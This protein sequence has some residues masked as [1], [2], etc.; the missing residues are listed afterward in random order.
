VSGVL[1]NL[2]IYYAYLKIFWSWMGFPRATV[3][4]FWH[5]GIKQQWVTIARVLKWLLFGMNPAASGLGFFWGSDPEITELGSIWQLI[6]GGRAALLLDVVFEEVFKRYFGA[7]GTAAIV[8]VEAACHCSF[9]Y[10]PVATMHVAAS[11]LPLTGGV[12]LHYLWNHRAVNSGG[13]KGKLSDTILSVRFVPGSSDL[14]GVCTKDS[15]LDLAFPAKRARLLKWPSERPDCLSRSMLWRIGPTVDIS[16]PLCFYS[17]PHNDVAAVSRRI[18]NGTAR[19]DSDLRGHM[20]VWRM[21]RS[22]NLLP[23]IITY[24]VPQVSFDGWAA[25]YPEAFRKRLS[26]WKESFEQEGLTSSDFKIEAFVK[27]ERLPLTLFSSDDKDRKPRLIQGRRGKLKVATGPWFKWAGKVLARNW[28]GRSQLY[29]PSGASAEE[30][31]QWSS[32][33]EADGLI[34]HCF[35]FSQWDSTVGPGASLAWLDAC[36]G[37]GCPGVIEDLALSRLRQVVG[38]TK[39]RAKYTKL[40]QVSSGDGDTSVGNSYIQGLGWLWVLHQVVPGVAANC[41]VMV[42]GDDSVI[43]APKQLTI[44]SISA[45]WDRLGFK[46]TGGSTEWDTAQ[47]CSGR[48]WRSEGTRVFGPSPGR[49]IGKTFWS[50]INWGDSK[51]APWLRGVCLGLSLNCSHVPILGALVQRLLE[52]AGKGKIIED[53]RNSRRVRIEATKP[54]PLV[55]ASFEQLSLISNLSIRDLRRMQTSAASISSID[56]VFEGANWEELLLAAP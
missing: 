48:F 11:Q 45:C 44:A 7:F 41:R 32:R 23:E 4:D 5:F 16:M 15:G 36:R 27:I 19:W 10:L 12:L 43:A 47:F 20:R 26:V 9:D 34:P 38:R 28:N 31:G 21:V 8:C 53:Q 40:A 50:V 49:V 46:L 22:S 25:D 52:L 14:P 55:D 3:R 51:R 6:V 42:L 2:L 29:Y 13:P 18:C 37:M 56:H 33:A 39:F 17:C 1:I 30:I 35:D 54:N 24:D